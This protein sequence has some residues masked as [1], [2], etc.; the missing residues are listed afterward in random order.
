MHRVVL[1]LA[2]LVSTIAVAKDGEWIKN[3]AT[4]YFTREED[5]SKTVLWASIDTRTGNVMANVFNFDPRNKCGNNASAYLGRIGPYR[6]N[7]T[8]VNFFGVCVSGTEVNQPESKPGKDF[9][10]DEVQKEGHLSIDVGN[11][12]VLRYNTSGFSKVKAKILESK[13]AL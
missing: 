12:H 3:D 9:F 11:G 7:G 2:I 5:G 13:S 4:S 1:V 8:L 10:M 6:V